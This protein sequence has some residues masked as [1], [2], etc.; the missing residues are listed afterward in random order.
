MDERTAKDVSASDGRHVFTGDAH[1]AS[2]ALLLESLDETVERIDAAD[3]A[4][5]SGAELGQIILVQSPLGDLDGKPDI[6][7]CTIERE[8][9]VCRLSFDTR[10]VDW[11]QL[12]TAASDTAEYY[13]RRVSAIGDRSQSLSFTK[14]VV[15]H[16][17]EHETSCRLHFRYDSNQ[18][19]VHERGHHATIDS[20]QSES[21][22]SG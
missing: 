22:S 12:R 3:R 10:S 19:S 1:L 17:G 2:L 5:N 9:L 6:A 11:R 15:H 20:P 14:E 16:S 8:G 7:T 13:V 18:Q 4:S 21:S